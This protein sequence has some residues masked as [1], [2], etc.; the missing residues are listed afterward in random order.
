MVS[1]CGRPV[2]RRRVRRTI[3][4][5][6]LFIGAGAEIGPWLGGV[7]HDWTGNYFSAFSVAHGLTLT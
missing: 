3:G 2:S 5:I 7:I 6:A 1:Y 4:A